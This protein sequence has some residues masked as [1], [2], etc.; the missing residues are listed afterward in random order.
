MKD[1]LH[2]NKDEMTTFLSSLRTLERDTEADA[3]AEFLA[4]YAAGQPTYERPAKPTWRKCDGRQVGAKLIRRWGNGGYLPEGGRFQVGTI[5]A[6]F[7]ITQD[8]EIVDIRVIVAKH[9]AAAWLI[10]DTIA[11]SRVSQSKLRRMRSESPEFFPIGLCA[12]W[13][14][15]EIDAGLTPGGTIRGFR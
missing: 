12:W 10:V 11:E 3:F 1:Y 13:D 4:R 8:G 2:P 15:N 5:A 7:E 6:T 9:P 14:Y